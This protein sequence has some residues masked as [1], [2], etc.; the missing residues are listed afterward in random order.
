MISLVNVGCMPRFFFF[1]LFQVFVFLVYPSVLLKKYNDLS[2]S[3]RKELGLANS[4]S[5]LNEASISQLQQKSQ[6][7]RH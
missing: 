4:Q 5:F 7:S 3:G 6:V 2:S 1:F